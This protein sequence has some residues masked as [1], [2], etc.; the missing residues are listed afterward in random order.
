MQIDHRQLP[1]RIKAH[2]L[3]WFRG[4]EGPRDDL[5]AHIADCQVEEVMRS[6]RR[7]R[8]PGLL[9]AIICMTCARNWPGA[10]WITLTAVGAL[11]QLV[12]SALLLPRSPWGRI[13]YDN[14]RQE[15]NALLFYA[16]TA[17]AIWAM[18]FAQMIAFAPVND[19]IGWITLDVAFIAIGTTTFALVPRACRFYCA[20]LTVALSATMLF[21]PLAMPIATKLL[22]PVF[23]FMIHQGNRNTFRQFRSHLVA[24]WTLQRHQE[25]R[26]TLNAETRQREAAER[27]LARQRDEEMRRVAREQ[28]MMMEEHRRQ[29]TLE[30]ADRYERSVVAHALELEDVVGSLVSAIDRIH[31]A[32][33]AVRSSADT[34]LGLAADSTDATQAVADSTDRLSVAADDIGGQVQQQRTAAAASDRAGETAQASLDALSRETDRI[35]EIVELVQS[36]AAQTNLLA[37]NAT[38]EASRAG[39]AGRGFAVVASEVKQLAAQTQGAINRIGDI[40]GATRSRMREMQDSMNAIAHSVDEAVERAGHIVSAVDNQR[41]ATRTIGQAAESTAEIA[42]QLRTVAE[43]VVTDIGTTDKHTSEIKSAIE[44]LRTRSQALRETSDTFLA[45]LRSAA[46]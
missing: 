45:Q 3:G 39:E 10:P 35:G 20:V 14:V 4:E 23:G 18:L 44:S 2:V 30:I 1:G 16:L 19:R 15:L 31:H 29:G 34:M 32:G 13:R 7:T 11:S 21:E 22:V 9:V 40:V 37:L 24:S 42:G 25:E 46:G 36:L 26:E 12:L 17:S 28:R 6:V 33:V 27:E 41:Q 8:L 38:I 5:A 43:R